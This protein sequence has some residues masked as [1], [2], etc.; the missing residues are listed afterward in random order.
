MDEM[1]ALAES[2]EVSE[3]VVRRVVIAMGGRQDNLGRSDPRES[4]QA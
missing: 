1:A 3:P 2:R 4:I